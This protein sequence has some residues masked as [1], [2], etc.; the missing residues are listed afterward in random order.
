VEWSEDHDGENN[1]SV[2]R[3]QK[4]YTYRMHKVH[5]EYKNTEQRRD[6]RLLRVIQVCRR[7]QSTIAEI[8][9]RGMVH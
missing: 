5:S 7:R 6:R 2:K 4:D 3:M 1:G 9:R 8:H